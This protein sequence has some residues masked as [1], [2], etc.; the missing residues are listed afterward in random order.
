MITLGQEG[1]EGDT[2]FWFWF[3]LVIGEFDAANGR[4]ANLLAALLSIFRCFRAQSCGRACPPQSMKPLRRTPLWY[5]GRHSRMQMQ[6][7]SLYFHFTNNWLCL[8]YR[9]ITLC[10]HLYL[11]EMVTESHSII[12][13]LLTISFLRI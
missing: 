12:T 10:K 5:G 11:K 7:L 2:V 6:R 13:T 8:F 3:H 9:V 1:G 4:H